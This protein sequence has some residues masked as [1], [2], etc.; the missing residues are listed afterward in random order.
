[1]ESVL[2]T[3]Q[4][5]VMPEIIQAAVSYI[6]AHMTA[7]VPVQVRTSPATAVGQLR[8]WLLYSVWEAGIIKSTGKILLQLPTPACT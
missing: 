3:A 8:L 7:R 1:M 6:E 5:L 4:Y 2:R